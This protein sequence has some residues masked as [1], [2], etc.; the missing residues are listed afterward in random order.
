M[1]DVEVHL[2]G[3]FWA[4]CL[5]GLSAEEGGERDN[6]EGKRNSTEHGGLE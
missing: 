6:E 2:M 1:L 5:Y 4:L 3:D